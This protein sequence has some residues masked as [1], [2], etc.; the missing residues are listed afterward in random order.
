MLQ[1]RLNM[2]R[3]YMTLFPI[4]LNHINVNTPAI[5][6][7]HRSRDTNEVFYFDRIL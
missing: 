6:F 1:R 7:L 2:R 4:Q 3:S 5:T